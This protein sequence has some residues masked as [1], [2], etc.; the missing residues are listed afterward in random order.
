M[1]AINTW[2]SVKLS[3]WEQSD[4]LC[5]DGNTPGT[6]SYFVMSEIHRDV[7]NVQMTLFHLPGF[8]SPFDLK[9]I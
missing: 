2:H 7:R 3:L 8:K 1:K 6:A 9:V 4:Y 5:V